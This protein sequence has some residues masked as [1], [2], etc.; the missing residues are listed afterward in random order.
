[1]NIVQVI[2]PFCGGCSYREHALTWVLRQ[3]R[4][5]TVVALGGQPWSKG[6]TLWPALRGSKADIIVLSDADVWTDGL[7]AAIQAVRDGAAWAMPHRYVFRLTRAA[8]AAFMAGEAW[9]AGELDRAPYEG[10]MGG[11]YVVARRE[12]LLD[13]P[14]DPRFVA[15]GQEDEAHAM[16]LTCI[17]GAGWR[18]MAPLVHLWHPPA[19]RLNHRIGSDESWQLRHEYAR[20]R[21][22][23]ERMMS[24]L[25][26]AHGSLGSPNPP[27]SSRLAAV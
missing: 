14:V 10:V 17:W 1:M 23:R 27:R 16:A 24:V 9:Q 8:T 13:V 25:K 20:A 11:G 19:P 3:S 4:Y 21:C 6:A 26:D 18:G 5:D 15:W 22:D 7:G 2:I 12:V